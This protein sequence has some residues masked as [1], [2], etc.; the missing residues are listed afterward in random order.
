MSPESSLRLFSCPTPNIIRTWSKLPL[1]SSVR[2]IVIYLPT[3]IAI[4][5][6]W[7]L[8]SLIGILIIIQIISGWILTLF[9]NNVWSLR[10]DSVW[11][12]HLDSWNGRL[13]HWIH[14]NFSS[15]IFLILYLHLLKGLYFQRWKTNKLVWIR[16][17]VLIVLIMGARFLGYVL[18][19]GQISLWGA[20]VITNLISVI[21]PKLVVWIWAGFS[22]NQIT[23]GFFFTLHYT[24]PF[25]VLFLVVVHL[26]RLHTFGRTNF[27]LKGH[28]WPYFV[29]KDLLNLV[30]VLF[31]LWCRLKLTYYTSDPDNFIKANPSNSPLH[32][33]PEWYFLQF[34]A[35]LRR[36]PNKTLGVIIFAIRLVVYPLITLNRQKFSTYWFPIW[37]FN[38]RTFVTIN[39]LLVIIGGKPVEYPFLEIGQILTVIYFIWVILIVLSPRP[40]STRLIK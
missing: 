11:S 24:L 28:F 25:V 31:F 3:P 32:I 18:P 2:Q 30:V 35:I 37:R 12:I 8:G 10:F 13:I 7:N 36:I 6:W 29:N 20:T 14:L 19:A 33:K 5:Y 22:V 9:Y 34:Y 38:V 15:F 26:I 23:L 39:L 40:F 17:F 16:G 1:V 27:S 21:R 4:S